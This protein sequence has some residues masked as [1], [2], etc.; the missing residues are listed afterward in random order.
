MHTAN[1]HSHVDAEVDIDPCSFLAVSKA[2]GEDSAV[3][4]RDW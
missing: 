2:I 4:T 1:S 3:R